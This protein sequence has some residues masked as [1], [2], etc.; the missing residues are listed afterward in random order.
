MFGWLWLTRSSS[1]HRQNRNGCEVTWTFARG[2]ALT[3]PSLQILQN[4]F[5]EIDRTVRKLQLYQ[6]G[7]SSSDFHKK[8]RPSSSTAAPTQAAGVYGAI[9]GLFGR[10]RKQPEVGIALVSL[11]CLAHP[12]L[13]SRRNVAR[14]RKSVV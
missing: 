2:V 6:T 14:D 9:T 11:S 5:T 13:A 4:P 7:I 3:A 10:F 1:S 8:G 12:P